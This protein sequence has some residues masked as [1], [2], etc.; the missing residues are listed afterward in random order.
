[1]QE[2]DS[3]TDN[4]NSP[5]AAA[6]LPHDTNLWPEG[7]HRKLM[8]AFNKLGPLKATPQALLEL[9]DWPGLTESDTDRFLQV[10]GYDAR[11]L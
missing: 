9:V 11:F 5:N 1:M 10:G 6:T 3:N 4:N 7:L 8:F 2:K